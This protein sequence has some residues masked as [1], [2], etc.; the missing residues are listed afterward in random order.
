MEDYNLVTRFMKSMGKMLGRC[1]ENESSS[2]L[3]GY[4]SVQFLS[5][6]IT[7]QTDFHYHLYLIFCRSC[8]EAICL[9]V[10]QPHVDN[11]SWM[12]SR[13][14]TIMQDLLWQTTK[15]AHFWRV[16]E[17]IIL[18]DLVFQN[19]LGLS[20]LW[21]SSHFPRKH[22]FNHWWFFFSMGLES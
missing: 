2:L 22:W 3:G 12:L 1:H 5:P 18:R 16:I 4:N 14:K 21:E 8:K 15:H 10:C 9:K 17:F 11:V 7:P 20:K 6:P 13:W 19:I